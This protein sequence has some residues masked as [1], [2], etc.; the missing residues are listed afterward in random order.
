MSILIELVEY[1]RKSILFYH[2][3]DGHLTAIFPYLGLA[4]LGRG[5]T[6]FFGIALC[7]RRSPTPAMTASATDGGAGGA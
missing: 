4:G 1:G 7:S 5:R 6:D 3:I 2:I